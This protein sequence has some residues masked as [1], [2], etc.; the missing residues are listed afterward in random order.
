MWL[1]L[2]RMLSPF[3]IDAMVQTDVTVTIFCPPGRPAEPTFLL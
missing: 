1:K 2:L 3:M